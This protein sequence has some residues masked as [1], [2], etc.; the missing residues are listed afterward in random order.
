MSLGVVFKVIVKNMF[1]AQSYGLQVMDSIIRL[2]LSQNLK[3]GVWS[4]LLKAFYSFDDFKKVFWVSFYSKFA[5]FFSKWWKKYL[6]KR[7]LIKR[8]CSW[9]GN[10]NTEQ[11]SENIF[12]HC[13]LNNK[14]LLNT[15][16]GRLGWKYFKK[17]LTR[18][19]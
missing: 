11:T 14:D 3:N 9:R 4:I 17:T 13:I 7:S 6:S 2:A 12:T 5:G 18:S 16:H 15:S 19:R 10:L 8:T 1:K